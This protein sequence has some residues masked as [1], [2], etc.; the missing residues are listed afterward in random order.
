MT[1]TVTE[2]RD[3]L[4]LKKLFIKMSSIFCIRLKKH[5][6]KCNFLLGKNQDKSCFHY[7]LS[8]LKIVNLELFTEMVIIFLLLRFVKC[9]L[10]YMEII[11]V[12]SLEMLKCCTEGK[13]IRVRKNF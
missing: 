13:V 9:G 2:V 7:S 12:K 5:K 1:Y 4:L 8:K 3:R 11:V 10:I 6:N